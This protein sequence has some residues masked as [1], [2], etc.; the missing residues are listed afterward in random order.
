M[1]AFP[2][3]ACGH[4]DNVLCLSMVSLGLCV[5]FSNHN[6]RGLSGWWVWYRSG[7][8]SFREREAFN[9]LYLLC[10]LHLC[11]VPC[12]DPAYFIT[13]KQAGW[14]CYFLLN[15]TNE[16]RIFS[17]VFCSC[18]LI[19]VRAINMSVLALLSGFLNGTER[20]QNKKAHCLLC[21]CKCC[22]RSVRAKLFCMCVC[23]FPCACVLHKCV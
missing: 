16:E 17:S 1:C 3:T 22:D 12:H 10:L 20:L 11:T 7:Q 15:C 2:H 19:C 21:V 18:L 8:I 5:Q 6:N 14:T 23:V 13:H 4:G 9:L